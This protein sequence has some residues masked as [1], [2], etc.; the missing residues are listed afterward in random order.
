MKFHT[1][2]VIHGEISRK[3]A[4]MNWNAS[5]YHLHLISN[6]LGNLLKLGESMACRHLKSLQSLSSRS[7][8]LTLVIK[9][10]WAWSWMT[11]SNPFWPWKFKVKIIAKIKPT[12]HI[13]GLEFN[14]YVC[15]S[16]RGS[17][18]IFGRDIASSIF[19]LE[20]SRS[21][22]WPR[23]HLRLRVQLICLHFVLWQLDHFWGV[24]YSK[25]QTWIFSAINPSKRK[26][27]WEIV[28]KLLQE[29]CLQPAASERV[30]AYEL[31]QKH[32]VTPGIQGSLDYY[33]DKYNGFT[34]D[35]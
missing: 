13:W 26:E 33:W 25:F 23:S 10:S 1:N 29:K 15:F 27:I 6:V 21:R 32:K 3:L 31:V 28:S 5:K 35:M 34:P 22:S 30:A 17:Q 14:Q 16:F 8:H 9:R 20:N 19:D 12:G 4:A 18:T 24:R 7:L 2:F 11:N